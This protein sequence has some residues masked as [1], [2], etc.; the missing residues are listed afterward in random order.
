MFCSSCHASPSPFIGLGLFRRRAFDD[1]GLEAVIIFLFFSTLLSY[2]ALCRCVVTRCFCF[3]IEIAA[4]TI[5]AYLAL[6][7]I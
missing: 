6:V 1:S 2:C 4:S 3:I 7:D 5:H